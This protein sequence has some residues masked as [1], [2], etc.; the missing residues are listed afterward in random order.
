MFSFFCLHQVRQ[1]TLFITTHFRV[2]WGLTFRQV[3]TETVLRGDRRK[4]VHLK[5]ENVKED[6][7]YLMIV[8]LS[9]SVC[10]LDY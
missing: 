7:C 10:K 8:R 3:S 6:E 1:V 2:F 9:K 5:F 4:K